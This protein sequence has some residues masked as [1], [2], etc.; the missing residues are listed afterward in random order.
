VENFFVFVI[1]IDF[2]HY[3]QQQFAKV[4]VECRLCLESC[5]IYCDR[6]VMKD[7]FCYEHHVILWRIKLNLTTRIVELNL[8]YAISNLKFVRTKLIKCFYFNS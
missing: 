1:L 6:F 5:I 8:K 3:G 7:L 2:S 4:A